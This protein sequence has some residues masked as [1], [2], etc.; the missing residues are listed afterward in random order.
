MSL[1]TNWVKE[2]GR[3][4]KNKA[5]ESIVLL[6]GDDERVDLSVRIALY[7]EETGGDYSAVIAAAGNIPLYVIHGKGD[8]KYD[9]IDTDGRMARDLPLERID[10]DRSEVARA[11]TS[12]ESLLSENST[13]L[14]DSPPP[15]RITLSPAEMLFADTGLPETSRRRPITGSKK[16]P[17]PRIGRLR[18]DE[19]MDTNYPE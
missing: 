5:G 4:V 7:H 6:D 1:A 2:Y 18:I 11:L 16:R 17:V 8:D 9:R 13:V 14:D 12:V 10:V 15:D 3:K 19:G